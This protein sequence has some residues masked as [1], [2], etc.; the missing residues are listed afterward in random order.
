MKLHRIEQG[1]GPLVV[2]LHG[3]PEFWYSWRK[4]IPALVNAGFR[5]VAPDLRGYNDSPKPR[6]VDAYRIS[7]VIE[8]VVELLHDFDGE[9]CVL[10]GHD[11]GGVAAWY[12]AM[13]HPELVRK[14]VVLNSPHP[15]PLL[16]EIKRSLNQRIRMMYQLFFQVPSAA[17]LIRPLLPLILRGRFTAE[18]KEEYRKSWRKPDVVRSM[19]S[20]YPA[21][22]RSGSELR[23]ML[24]LI[25]APTLYIFGT[26]DPV[27]TIETSRNFGTWVPNARV[28]LIEG[29]GHFVQ[30]DAAERVSE[31]LIEFAG[32]SGT[33]ASPPADS[34]LS[35]S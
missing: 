4:Q 9:P 25:E 10:V 29:A 14:L 12:T 16:R 21:L 33:P 31:L 15:K 17:P 30:T 32:L 1:S 28:E 5:V 23:E 19:L 7:A 18:E 24:R 8:D 11:W 2:L 22:W 35:V 27:F 34:G 3:F 20:Y 26:R 6:N 13:T